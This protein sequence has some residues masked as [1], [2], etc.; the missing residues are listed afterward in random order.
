MTLTKLADN[1][2]RCSVVQCAFR[3]I[4]FRPQ[5]LHSREMG[6]EKRLFQARQ[7]GSQPLQP[8]SKELR[9]QIVSPQESVVGLPTSNNAQIGEHGVSTHIDKVAVAFRLRAR[10]SAR[11]LARRGQVLREYFPLVTSSEFHASF[12]FVVS[13]AHVACLSILSDAVNEQTHSKCLE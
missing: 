3:G 5:H 9:W 8:W 6:S 1:S 13:R 11:E 10:W 4:F 7:R 12:G 2:R